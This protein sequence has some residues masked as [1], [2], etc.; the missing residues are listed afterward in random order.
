MDKRQLF[1]K[2]L[3]ELRKSKGLTQKELGRRLNV[4]E[5]AVGM[6]EQELPGIIPSVPGQFVPPVAAVPERSAAPF[7]L[8][9]Q[10]RPHPQ[11]HK[12]YR[13]QCQ[14]PSEQDGSP[15]KASYHHLGRVP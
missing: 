11:P 12:A 6:W 3:R 2:R 4:T 14:A 1:A 9:L 10:R 8:H 5:A 13:H 7:L 15:R